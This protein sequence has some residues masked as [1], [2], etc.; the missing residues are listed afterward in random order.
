MN[1]KIIGAAATV[2]ASLALLSSCAEKSP[3]EIYAADGS[4]MSTVKNANYGKA[5]YTVDGYCEYADMA[6]VEAVEIISEK[7]G[8]SLEEAYKGITKKGYVIETAFDTEVYKNMSEASLPSVENLTS[9]VT[10]NKGAVLCVYAV[11]EDDA[12]D[13]NAALTPHYPGSSIKPLSVY[14][15][16]IESG[17][18]RWSSIIEDS[19]VKQ[20]ENDMGQMRDW[21]EN[22]NG[23][24]LGEGMLLENAVRESTNTVAVKVLQRY[25]VKEAVDFIT[26]SFGMNTEFERSVMEK[27]G[28]DEILSN[29]A[30]GYLR[31]GVTAVDMAGYYQIFANNGV[32]YEPYTV[33]KITDGSGNVIYEAE[34]QG[35]QVISESTAYIMNRLL[36]GVVI[37]GGTGVAAQNGGVALGGKTG[38][39][40]IMDGRGT[41]N[42]FIGFTPNYTCSVWHSAED[43]P[44]MAA[45]YF[46]SLTKNFNIGSLTDFRRCEGVEE[47]AYCGESGARFGDDCRELEVGYFERDSVPKKCKQNH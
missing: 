6:L 45:A 8:I 46:A 16:A 25:G 20:V 30:L 40:E 7:D 2:F 5:E 12:A 47:I 21:P 17:V 33:C 19:P 34:E 36:A 43:S 1:K 42:W 35:K 41:D 3:T 9:A 24:Y 4:L 27:A 37:K 32:Y 38:T 28:E 10:D 15:P 29:I 23:I 13:E 39:S 26:D 14:A 22:A 18:I 31:A 44:N 11:K